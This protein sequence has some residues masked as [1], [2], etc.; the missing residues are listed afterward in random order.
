MA[1]TKDLA[2][3]ATRK[4]EILRGAA[5]VFK[6]KGFHGARTEEI[7]AAIGLSPGTLFRYFPDKRAIILS[8]AEIEFACYLQEI[9]RLGT[10]EGLLWVAGI[11]GRELMSLI[12]AS[13]YDLGVDSWLELSR[14]PEKGVALLELDRTLRETLAQRLVKGQQEGWVK[15]S[16]NCIGTANI[17]LAIFTGLIVDQ[18]QRIT[19][20]LDATASALGSV[21][22]SIL[23]EADCRCP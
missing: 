17:L 3:S 15:P 5:R 4:E 6:E 23:V 7:C 16:V 8:I 10:K 11:S 18:Q 1:R 14:D 13:E 12:K 20:D 22:H 2:L 9:N 19:I 21:L